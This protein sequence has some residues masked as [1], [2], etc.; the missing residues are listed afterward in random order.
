MVRC[1][2][3]LAPVLV[4]GVSDVDA[5]GNRAAGHLSVLEAL[6]E[7]NSLNVGWVARAVLAVVVGEIDVSVGL[8]DD[9][10]LSEGEGREGGGL[11]E[12]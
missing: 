5:G 8:G 11:E 2:V 4:E 7:L 6:V 10:R 3:A 12:G 1:T 9:S